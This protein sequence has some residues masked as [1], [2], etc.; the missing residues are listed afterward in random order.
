MYTTDVYITTY[1]YVRTYSIASGVQGYS[2]V[3][4]AL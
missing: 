1:M 4:W 2:Q 3:R